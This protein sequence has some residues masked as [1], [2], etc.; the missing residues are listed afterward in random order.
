MRRLLWLLAGC[1]FVGLAAVGVVLPLLPTTPFLLLAAA[2]F[3]RSSERLHRWLR[4]QPRFGG[5]VRNW[6][7]HGVIPRR[8]KVLAT[9]LIILSLGAMLLH[10]R[11]QG[12][13]WVP[14]LALLGWG[15]SFIWS[16]PDA[17]TAP[18]ERAVGECG[19]PTS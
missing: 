15:L 12:W 3:A 19:P 9:L 14:I 13:L 1:F 6:Q 4:E 8:A 18:G 10:G 5:T 11:V 7:D 17:P 16:R 2:C